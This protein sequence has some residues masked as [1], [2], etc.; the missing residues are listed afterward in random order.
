MIDACAFSQMEYII[1]YKNIQHEQITSSLWKI[2]WWEKNIKWRSQQI[3]GD[4]SNSM[5]LPTDRST[6]WSDSN[7]LFRPSWLSAKSNYFSSLPF[8]TFFLVSIHIFILG[9]F[10]FSIISLLLV[11]N[12]EVCLFSFPKTLLKLGTFLSLLNYLMLTWLL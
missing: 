1:A 7:D 10:F 8:G 11:S 2:N 5:F 9:C 4:I 6:S 3:A 12:K